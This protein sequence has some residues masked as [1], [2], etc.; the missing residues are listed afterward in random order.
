MGNKNKTISFRVRE[1]KFEE[2][3]RIS[4]ERDLSLSTLFRDYVDMFISHDGHVETVPK[5]Q[6][7][8]AGNEAD[9]PVKVEVPKSFVREHERLEMEAKH[10]R[11]QLNE[12]KEYATRLNDQLDDHEAKREETIRLEELDEEHGTS[13]LLDDLDDTDHSQRSSR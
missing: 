2:L 13:M 1:D 4:E 8:T 11:E 5:H 12:Y 6:V 10:L 3:K 9:F 7:D